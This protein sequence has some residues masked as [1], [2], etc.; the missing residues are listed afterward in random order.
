MEDDG[1]KDLF[2]RFAPELSSDFRF[3]E[4]LQRGME[5]VELVKQRSAAARKRNRIAVM[6]SALSGFV[7]GVLF[8]LFLPLVKDCVSIVN[9]K[10]P[11]M[12]LDSVTVDFQITGWI[13]AA[14]VTTL[15]ACNAYV[16]TL[17]RLSLKER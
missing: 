9:L 7:T 4:R 3:M 15:A 13:A 16:I 2:G 17:S 8:M 11:Y 6:V 14:L 10:I 5:A 1:I 12:G